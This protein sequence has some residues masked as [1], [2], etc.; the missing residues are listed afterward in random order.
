M[1]DPNSRSGQL[2]GLSILRS[3]FPID[4]QRQGSDPFGLYNSKRFP[5]G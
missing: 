2:A 1:N 4:L 3:N 5:W